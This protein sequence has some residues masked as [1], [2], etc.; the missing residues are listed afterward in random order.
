MTDSNKKSAKIRVNLCATQPH[1]DA[2]GA[3][4][5]EGLIFY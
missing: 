3:R 1:R 5:K 2:F 4:K